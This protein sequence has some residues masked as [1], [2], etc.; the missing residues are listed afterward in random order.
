M[1]FVKSLFGIDNLFKF[2]CFGG[3]IIIGTALFYPNEM[4]RKID[5]DIIDYKKDTCVLQNEMSHLKGQLNNIK[6]DIESANGKTRVLALRKDS[7]LKM[8][9]SKENNIVELK[10]LNSQK[11]EIISQLLKEFDEKD[12]LTYNLTLKSVNVEC[13]NEKIAKAQEYLDNYKRYFIILIIIGFIMLIWGFYGWYGIQRKTNE[14]QDL[15]ISL[16]KKTL[17][18]KKG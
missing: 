3:L 7:I 14:M 6:N 12:K 9:S 8:K 15:Q 5:F 2:L 4:Q 1:D 18:E 17:E 16:A 13:G 11:D 10:K